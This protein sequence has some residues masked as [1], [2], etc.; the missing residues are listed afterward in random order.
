MSTKFT[1]ENLNDIIVESVVDSLNFNNEQAVLKARGG[2]AQLD[3]TS[4][5]R[6][7]NN[8]VEILKNAGVDESAIPNNVN[9]ENILVAKQVSDLINHSPEL[10]EIKNHISN[11]N[12][13]IDASD[14][15]SVLKLNSEKLIKNAA[16]D[17]LLRVSS[18]HHEPIGK[19]F[20]VSIP[21]FHGGSIRAQDLV[22]GLKIAG[23]YVSDSLL[24]IK[25]KVDLKVEDKQTSKPKLKM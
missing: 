1:K 13:K 19:G 10:R 11:G 17:V 15:S 25:S 16:S 7:S 20:D 4:F 6:F 3:E 14:A 24:E 21:A 9:V 5:Q 22:S 23:E 12:I 2:A 18:I 8:K